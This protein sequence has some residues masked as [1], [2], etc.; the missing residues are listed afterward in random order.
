MLL[1]LYVLVHLVLLFEDLLLERSAAAVQGSEL[2]AA[3]AHSILAHRLELHAH[4]EALLE[5]AVGAAL[6]LML[7]YL[8][9]LL[10]HARVQLL[11]LHGAL[12]EALAGLAREQAVVE[13]AHLVAAHRTQV[14]EAELDVQR[15]VRRFYVE[16]AH[17]LYVWLFENKTHSFS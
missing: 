6:A 2:V 7:V 1:L 10:V 3:A 4:L 14:V 8:T 15:H 13:A 9:R 17:G 5:A 11:V 16:H 12:E